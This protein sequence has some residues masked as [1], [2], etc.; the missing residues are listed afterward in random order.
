MPSRGSEAAELS[1]VRSLLEDLTARIGA[2]IEHRRDRDDAVGAA[3]AD[4][5]RSLVIAARALRR[6]AE[7]I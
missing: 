2:L 3:L 5:E 7:S 6:A 1:S 4:A